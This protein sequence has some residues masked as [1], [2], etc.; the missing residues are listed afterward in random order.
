MTS[1]TNYSCALLIAILLTYADA[2]RVSP[3]L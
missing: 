3:K 1:G 2:I